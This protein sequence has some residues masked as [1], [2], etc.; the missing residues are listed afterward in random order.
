MSVSVA[1]ASMQGVGCDRIAMGSRASGSLAGRARA[2]WAAR[3]QWTCARSG[4]MEWRRRR[5][6]GSREGRRIGR[7]GAED[8][9]GN[10]AGE[11]GA[12]GDE[13]EARDV[14][15]DAAPGSLRRDVDW[16]LA[17]DAAVSGAGALAGGGPDDVFASNLTLA[18]GAATAAFI[19]YV[20]LQVG[21]LLFSVTFLA[22]K[23][24]AI[25][26]LLLFFITFLT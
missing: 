5:A 3:A 17:N 10:V 6:A 13:D 21:W 25:A 23:Y 16:L 9:L 7:A 11:G 22:V 18:L 20:V 19:A 26:I 2:R 24:G 14:S 8:G 15:S 1:S 4:S 12:L